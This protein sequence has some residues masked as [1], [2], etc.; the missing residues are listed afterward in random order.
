MGVMMY[1]MIVLL[2]GIDGEEVGV[3]LILHLLYDLELIPIL[4][5]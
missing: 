1:L 2:V 4:T 5:D 3:E